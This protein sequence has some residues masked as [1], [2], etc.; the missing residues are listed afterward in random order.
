MEIKTM[1]T[2]TNCCFTGNL[3][4]AVFDSQHVVIEEISDSGLHTTITMPPMAVQA[5]LS[6]IVPAS[7]R[8]CDCLKKKYGG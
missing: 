7:A 2:M 3:R 6:M 8:E 4:I 5:L 1:P